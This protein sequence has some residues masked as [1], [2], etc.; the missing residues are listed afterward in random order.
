MPVDP[1]EPTY[2]VCQQVSYGEMIGCDNT[3]VCNVFRIITEEKNV[4]Y[5][6]SFPFSVPDRMV[7]LCVCWPNN[8]TERQMVLS[9]VFT[10]SQEEIKNQNPTTKS[11]IANQWTLLFSFFFSIIC[12]LFYFASHTHRVSHTQQHPETLNT[13]DIIIFSLHFYC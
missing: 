13:H 12:I 6:L 8:K 2:C 11:T 10:G 3:E 7:P 9:E 5:R 4:S 1:N